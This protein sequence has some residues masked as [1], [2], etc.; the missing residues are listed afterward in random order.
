MIRMMTSAIAL[1]MLATAGVAVMPAQAQNVT[2]DSILDALKPKAKSKTRSLVVGDQQQDSGMTD[3]QKQFVRGLQRKTRAI[4]VEE[5][6]ELAK[7]V[8]EQKLPSIDL[9]VNFEYN[10][11]AI[12]HKAVPVLRELG[13]ALRNPSLKGAIIMLSGHTDASGSAQY[14]QDLSQR[15]AHSVREYL[16][17]TYGVHESQIIAVGYG[18]EQLKN[19]HYPDAPE[20]RRVQ[21]VNLGG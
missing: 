16:I 10:S 2:A 6:K 18:E 17:S 4:V 9:T 11:A 1:S 3:E 21:I 14:N 20:N 12:G 15:R 8:K 19:V 13:I 5:R 7:I